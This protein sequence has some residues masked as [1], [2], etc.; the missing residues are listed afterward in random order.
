MRYGTCHFDSKRSAN[1]YYKNESGLTPDQV[2]EK[3]N[4][5]SIVIGYPVK[6][7]ETDFIYLDSDGRYG[8]EEK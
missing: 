4:E 3:I 1:R 8:I 5:G 7:K 6:R 2:Q